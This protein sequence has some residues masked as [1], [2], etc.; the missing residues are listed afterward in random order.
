MIEG[1]LKQVGFHLLGRSG[2]IAMAEVMARGVPILAYHGVTEAPSSPLSNLRRLHVGV[3]RFE[4]HLRFLCRRRSPATLGT[5]VAALR[6]GRPPAPGTVVV[7]MDDGYRN[8]LTSAL[9]ILKR[10]GV[11]ATVFV[12]TGV[13]R[14]RRMWIDRLEAAIAATAASS[15][16]WDGR[17]LSLSSPAAKVETLRALTPVLRRLGPR[18]DAALDDLRSRLGDP[19]E[20]ADPDRD[21]LSW[22][23]VRALRDAGME[24]GSHADLHEPLTARPL[25]EVRSAL[26]RSRQSLETECGWRPY[27]LSYPYGSWTAG[28]AAAAREAGFYCAVSTDPGLNRPGGDAFGLRR[29]LVGADDTLPRLRASLSGLRDVLRPLHAGRGG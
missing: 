21:L 23:E 25:S 3:R 28:V 16:F 18:R 22:D 19:L 10:C 26:A 24:I 17:T 7:T 1:R 29:M 27:A 9:P 11:P 20:P 14:Y 2:I 5:V 4:E 13:E 6:E 8:T 12:L 15:L